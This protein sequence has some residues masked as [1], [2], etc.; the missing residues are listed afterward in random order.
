MMELYCGIR[1]QLNI[2]QRS[3]LGFLFLLI[4]TNDL[5]ESLTSS[6]KLLADDVSLFSIS[7]GV[8]LVVNN[9][10]NDLT[11]ISKKVLLEKMIRNLHPSKQ[12][13]EVIF[14]RKSKQINHP[15]ILSIKIQSICKSF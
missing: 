8:N 7:H 9:S 10:N 14:S 15:S 6:P 2:S 12:A 4:H 11:K 5:S 1:Q 3:I 13:H